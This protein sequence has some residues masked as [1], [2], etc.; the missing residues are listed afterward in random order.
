M[1]YT[2]I[3]VYLENLTGPALVY[4]ILMQAFWF[5][6]LFAVIQIVLRAGIRQLV[7]QGG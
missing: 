4:A 3:E 7:V 2:V 6:I 5:L 1:V